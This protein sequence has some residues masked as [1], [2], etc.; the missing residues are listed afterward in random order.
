MVPD[1]GLSRV[2]ELD[3]VARAQK[4]LGVSAEMAGVQVA[5]LL[6]VD[7]YA[8][9]AG[10]KPDAVGTFL[11]VDTLK[12]S[13]AT[14][15]SSVVTKLSSDAAGFQVHQTA[16][17]LLNSVL[18]T[19]GALVQV[20]SPEQVDQSLPHLRIDLAAWRAQLL[21]QPAG[22]VTLSELS[23]LADV[24]GALGIDWPAMPTNYSRGFEVTSDGFY[25][26]GASKTPSG[27]PQITLAASKVGLPISKTKL[28]THLST[29]LGPNG[30]LDGVGDASLQATYEASAILA[31]CGQ[32][33]PD[34]APLIESEL[35]EESSH[36]T[37]LRDVFQSLTLAQLYKVRVTEEQAEGLSIYVHAALNAAIAQ[38][39]YGSVALALF[40]NDTEAAR[41]AALAI[42]NF[43]SS[44]GDIRTAAAI[45]AITSIVGQD[46]SRA[47]ARSV[48]RNYQHGSGFSWKSAPDEAG[49][50]NDIY[51]T[52]Y[53][54]ASLPEKAAARQSSLTPFED[55]GVWS[56]VPAQVGKRNVTLDTLL[57]AVVITSGQSNSK[58]LLGAL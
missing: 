11:A 6:D 25:E 15:P 29:G 35:S 42:S 14:I 47:N 19:I 51:A 32:R 36:P 39:D 13:G 1:A 31:T 38:R 53:A 10:E 28:T 27:D 34:L 55:D 48:I 24:Y 45:V 49:A 2:T 56:N 12:A 54:Y 46:Q 33:L 20:E 5:S 7:Q 40:S 8:Q 44:P 3:L 57:C 21:A 43:S 16:S 37:N 58:L 41:K 30:W 26:L 52:A 22:A 18:P 23:N 50:P 4:A 17:A 9:N